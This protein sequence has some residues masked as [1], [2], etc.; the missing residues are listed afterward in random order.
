MQRL[1]PAPNI[2]SNLHR[3]GGCDW[4]EIGCRRTS[5]FRERLRFGECVVLCVFAAGRGRLLHAQ[6]HK[7][8]F[9][10]RS[11]AASIIHRI[12]Y[13]QMNGRS[14]AANTKTNRSERDARKQYK[15]CSS[16]PQK[17]FPNALPSSFGWQKRVCAENYMHF[18]NKLNK[19]TK[20][21]WDK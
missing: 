2:E 3:S 21:L 16:N 19:L 7:S 9:A 10:A 14:S 17:Y 13:V 18:G 8:M 4:A 11:P 6:Q 5:E 1:C 15:F 12:H 20:L